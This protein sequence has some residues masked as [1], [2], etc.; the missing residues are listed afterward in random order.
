MANYE[1]ASQ[2]C[3][4]LLENEVPDH[5]TYHTSEHTRNVV[6]A[7]EILASK[8]NVKGE[9]LMLLKTA[10]LF[11]DTGFTIDHNDHEKLSCE[12]AKQKLP[13]FGYT[14]LQI[15]RIC[16][17]I[18]AT[19]LPQKPLNHS[20]EILC[21]ADLIYLGGTDYDYFASKLYKEFKALGRISDKLEWLLL[22]K[23]FLKT[24]RFFTSTARKENSKEKKERLN[25]VITKLHRATGKKRVKFLDLLW[26]IILLIAAVIISGFALKGFLL[27]NH[28]FDGGISGVS[29]LV[30]DLFDVNLAIS[31]LVLNIPL[32]IISYF[33]I[34][35]RFALRTL[36]GIIMLSLALWLLPDI[37]FTNDKL[38]IAV[39]GGFFLGIGV[40]LGIRSGA[41]LDGIDV[42]A[43]YTFKKTSF[44]MTEIIMAINCLIFGVAAVKFGI[45]T[46]MYSIL[47]YFAATL[48]ADY[49]VEGLQAHIG[50][51][52]ISSKS[53]TIKSKLVNQ[54]GR[55][56]TIYK[57]ERGYLPGQF[58]VSED[59]DIIF[60]VISRLEM[61]KLKNLVYDIDDKA[62][63]IA[64]SIKEATGGLLSRR[65]GY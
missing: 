31:I 13:E 3:F 64:N 54:L 29:L 38:L 9:D 50:V 21:D 16:K 55:A 2:F 65:G 25:E 35:K 63:V 33:S 37:V 58:D 27:P 62:F 11:H 61:R 45:E 39:F 59:C 42:L 34:G 18:M 47:T 49:V 36:I 57:G 8:E 24:H 28:F 6:Q 15:D 1:L 41:A 30:S 5:I 22:Q 12:I 14:E 10:A 40:G 44:S 19:K 53:E 20:S 26:D 52:I 51:T 56:I 4:D 23:E 60:T 7:C 48:S 17:M 46:A 32:I 43:L